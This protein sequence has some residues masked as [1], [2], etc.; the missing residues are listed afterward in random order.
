MREDP[1][2]GPEGPPDI[3]PRLLRQPDSRRCLPAPARTAGPRSLGPPSVVVCESDLWAR[4]PFVEIHVS[5]GRIYVTVELPGASRESIDVEAS[6]TRIAIRA[7]SD[8]GFLYSRDIDLPEVVE[9]H[10]IRATY[11]N[12][13]L[14]IMIPRSP[15][16]TV[17]I[18]GGEHNA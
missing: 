9:P 12:G 8:N 3:L 13:V 17:R 1:N 16:R 4:E 7:R 15:S 5:P 14:D 18:E 10:G 2:P 11:R 6:T